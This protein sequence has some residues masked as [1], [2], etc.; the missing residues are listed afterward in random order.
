M[1]VMHPYLWFLKHYSCGRMEKRF[2]RKGKEKL[3]L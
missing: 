2:Y 3:E 1:E